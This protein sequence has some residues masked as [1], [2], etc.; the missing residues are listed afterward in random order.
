MARKKYY[1]HTLDGRPGAF[2]GTQICY[3]WHGMPLAK[4]LQQIRAEQK[5]SI[6]HRMEQR[7][8]VSNYGY[9]LV[10]LVD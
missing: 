9:L 8:D 1:L 7:L 10:Y 3:A 5:R 2:D 4:T 6:E